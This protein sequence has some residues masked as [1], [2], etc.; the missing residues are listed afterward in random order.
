VLQAAHADKQMRRWQVALL[1]ERAQD[2]K[3]RIEHRHL[4]HALFEV[5]PLSPSVLTHWR[6]SLL[7][8]PPRFQL[9][10]LLTS[11][12]Q[13]PRRAMARMGV[14]PREPDPH[15]AAAAAAAARAKKK[16]QQQ[17]QQQQQKLPWAATSSASGARSALASFAAASSGLAPPEL[18][19]AS[20]EE[21]ASPSKPRG[22]PT[23]S[24]ASRSRFAPTPPRMSSS[25]S[26]PM[27]NTPYG[28]VHQGSSICSSELGLGDDDEAL[29]RLES[30]HSTVRHELADLLE[31]VQMIQQQES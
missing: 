7:T 1:R 2:A 30:E 13:V 4:T 20:L 5:R 3:D 26:R 22:I 31:L 11:A 15:R 6:V 29:A 19:R 21:I 16:K 18:G 9:R 8:H 17:Q 23:G 14:T 28:P 10:R 25:R 12:S 27:R 24:S